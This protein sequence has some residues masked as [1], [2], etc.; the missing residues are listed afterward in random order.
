MYYRVRTRS[1]NGSGPVLG[2]P[3]FG[4]IHVGE[5]GAQYTGRDAKSR[6]ITESLN[7]HRSLNMQMSAA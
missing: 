7:M 4:I 1:I 5:V 3:G 6:K 2:I